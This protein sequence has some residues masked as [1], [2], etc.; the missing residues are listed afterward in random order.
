[1]PIDARR[2]CRHTRRHATHDG[3]N[4]CLFNTGVQ[5]AAT[6]GSNHMTD[7]AFMRYLGQPQNFYYLAFAAHGC[8]LGVLLRCGS[9]SKKT[10]FFPFL[11]SV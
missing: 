7:N 11:Q 10:A 9:F 4:Q 1:M 3:A 6:T 5:A 8:R 2:L